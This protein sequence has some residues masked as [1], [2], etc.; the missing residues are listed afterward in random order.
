[1]KYNHKHKLRGQ[2]F[3][4]KHKRVEIDIKRKFEY[5]VCYIHHNLIHHK[6]TKEYEHWKYSSF[7]VFLKDSETRIDRQY[8]LKQFSGLKAFV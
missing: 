6:F 5:M 8:V 4:N 3:L 1:M 2:L 7:N